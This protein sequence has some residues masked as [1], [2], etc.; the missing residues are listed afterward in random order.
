VLVLL[1]RLEFPLQLLYPQLAEQLAGQE[2]KATLGR[3]VLDQVD[4]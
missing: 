2:A 3:E 4:N 1:L